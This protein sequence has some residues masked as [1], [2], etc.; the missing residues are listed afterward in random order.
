MHKGGALRPFVFALNL[1][2]SAPNQKASPLWLYDAVVGLQVVGG[3][4]GLLQR[5]ANKYLQKLEL[6]REHEREGATRGPASLKD[7]ASYG[8]VQCTHVAWSQQQ[9][10]LVHTQ[11]PVRCHAIRTPAGAQAPCCNMA[12]T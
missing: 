1:F 11:P 5:F 10:G 4:A 9:Q 2:L 3:N 7:A 6:E 12:T 8:A